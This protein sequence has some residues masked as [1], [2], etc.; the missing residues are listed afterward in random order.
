MSAWTPIVKPLEMYSIDL[1]TEVQTSL[2]TLSGNM[3]KR[4][5]TKEWQKNWLNSLSTSPDHV[6]PTLYIFHEIF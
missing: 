2:H 4:S 1:A 3:M 5:A 6:G